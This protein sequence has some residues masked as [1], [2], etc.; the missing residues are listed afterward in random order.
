MVSREKKLTRTTKR[1][2]YGNTGTS[3]EYEEKEHEPNR[4]E[5]KEPGGHL[6]ARRGRQWCNVG[7]GA[8]RKEYVWGGISINLFCIFQKEL[9]VIQEIGAMGYKTEIKYM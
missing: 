7:K 1:R 5:K 4:K 8:K 2:G 9:P 3:L 6:H